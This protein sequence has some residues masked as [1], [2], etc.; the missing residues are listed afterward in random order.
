M[1]SKGNRL[2]WGETYLEISSFLE[3]KPRDC[4]DLCRPVLITGPTAV[5]K[6]RLALKIAQQ[7][8]GVIINADAMQVYDAAPILT[9]SPSIQNQGLVPHRL[10]GVASPRE[11]W[12][13]GVWLSKTKEVLAEVKASGRSPVIVGG[14]GLYF[15]ALTGSFVE[16]PPIDPDIRERLRSEQSTYEL[17]KQLA[18]YD[19]QAAMYLSPN[20]RVR[21]IRA[22]EVVIST[23]RTLK[24]WQTSSVMSP[25]ISKSQALCLRMSIDRTMLHDRINKRVDNMIE[26]GAVREVQSLMR[27]NLPPGYGV[28]KAIG[29]KPL[30]SY[31]KEEISLD[32]ARLE[33]KAQTRQYAKRQETWFRHRMSDWQEVAAP[34]D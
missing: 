28:M 1:C 23:G 17:Q 7:I 30:S 22:L 9:S 3:D 12:S 33:A 25:V 24:D 31:L 4:D 34:T 6:S 16:I 14:V 10:Y 27:L 18:M 19:P 21:M 26:S 13:T 8:G 32:Q 29:I 5:G 2:D 15:F 11:D 20:D